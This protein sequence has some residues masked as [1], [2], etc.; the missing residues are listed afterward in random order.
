MTGDADL[1]PLLHQPV[2]GR[3]MAYLYRNR[4]ARFALLRDALDVT[5]GNLQGHLAKLESAGY[6]TSSRVLL[7][8]FE[9]HYALT[10]QGAEAF[11]AYVARLRALIEESGVD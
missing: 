5:P 9:T 4:Q 3:I 6:V 8:M 7:A 1:D 10:P 2:R 11:R